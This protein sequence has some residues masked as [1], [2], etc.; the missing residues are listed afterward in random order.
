MGKNGLDLN[1]VPAGKQVAVV[2]N[3][4]KLGGLVVA[5]DAAIFDPTFDTRKMAFAAFMMAGAQG[6]ESI[7]SYVFGQK[8]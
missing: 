1:G 2:T 5:V 4:I 7:L 6:I 3:L 8:R